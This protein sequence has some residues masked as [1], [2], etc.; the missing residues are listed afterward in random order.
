M[1]KVMYS[2]VKQNAP[3]FSYGLR[4]RGSMSRFKQVEVVTALDAVMELQV[5][6]HGMF[7]AWSTLV[8]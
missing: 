1:Q 8:C 2:N 4:K 3:I 7:M 5:I 6:L